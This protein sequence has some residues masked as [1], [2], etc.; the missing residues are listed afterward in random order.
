LLDHV[1]SPTGLV[2]PVERLVRELS[3]RGVE[4]L[5]DGAHAPGMIDLDL[6]TLGATYYT[7]NCHKWLCAPKG[8]GF[9]YVQADRQAKVRPVVI[10]HGANTPRPGRSRFHD[11]FDWTG[12]ADPTPFLCVP[13]ALEAMAALVEGGWEEIRRRNRELA[14]AARRI[15]AEALGV[16]PPA[17]E[18]MIA[19]LVSFPLPDGASAE[20]PSSPLYADA[21]QDELL[22]RYRIEVPVVP[23]PAPPRRLIRISAQLYNSEDE[24]R[25]LGE[26]LR[27]LGLGAGQ[28][29]G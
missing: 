18:E 19:T 20:P 27:E 29:A 21:L 17:P 24:Y 16:A 22:A 13:V 2:L 28:R 15:L 9:L 25:K 11:E 26:A 6:G 14:F 1:T 23:W 8:A 12:T 10:S 7:G 3:A 5:I 4:T